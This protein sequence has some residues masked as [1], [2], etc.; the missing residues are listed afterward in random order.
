MEKPREYPSVEL[1]YG[2]CH[3]SKNNY[4]KPSDRNSLQGKVWQSAEKKEVF[5]DGGQIDSRLDGYSI[6]VDIAEIEVKE[7][8]WSDPVKKLV[9]VTNFNNPKEGSKVQHGFPA[10]RKPIV[11]RCFVLKGGYDEADIIEII[12]N[13]ITKEEA[14][15][16]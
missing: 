14:K 13:E 3:D 15:A 9:A 5:I 16:A 11:N 7:T 4:P 6:I 1:H 2:G 12:Q 10:C 8:P